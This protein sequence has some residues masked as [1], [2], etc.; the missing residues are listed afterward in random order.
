MATG[1]TT[2]SELEFYNTF[3][4]SAPLKETTF[5]SSNLSVISETTITNEFVNLGAKRFWARVIASFE[6]K[7]F[8]G[9]TM[10]SNI[11]YDIYGNTLKSVVNN[12]NIETKTT[13]FIQF[14]AWALPYLPNPDILQKKYPERDK[15]I[16]LI[17][18][19]LII[20]RSDSS[21][22]KLNSMAWQKA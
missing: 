18:K 8:E 4:V 14:E 11:T 17:L 12:N 19:S 1:F 2:T 22:E 9:R 21:Q 7:V 3:Y 16:I 20:T 13:D 15:L 5:L 10:S 6:N